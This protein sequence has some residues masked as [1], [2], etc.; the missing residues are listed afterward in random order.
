MGDSKSSRQVSLLV[1]WLP[2][3]QSV[4]NNLVRS[5]LLLGLGIFF[6]GQLHRRH[7]HL[8]AVLH[9]HQEA[10]QVFAAFSPGAEVSCVYVW[11]G[12]CLHSG[13]QEFNVHEIS[14]SFDFNSFYL[15]SNITG[16]CTMAKFNLSGPGCNSS[17]G[18]DPRHFYDHP[19]VDIDQRVSQCS[20]YVRTS[21]VKIRKRLDSN[22]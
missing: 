1:Q 21:L 3:M 7:E 17:W 10:L 19:C 8:S 20:M 18:T 5:S 13:D 14:D 9:G 2:S 12:A 15:D 22:N 16:R 6:A 11:V 4:R